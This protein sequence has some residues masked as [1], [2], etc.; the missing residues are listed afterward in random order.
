MTNTRMSFWLI[1][2][3]AQS[4]VWYFTC[5]T[6]KNKCVFSSWVLNK[7]PTPQSSGMPP[8]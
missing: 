7:A 3:E 2:N 8:Q 1:E 6:P 4:T 5:V